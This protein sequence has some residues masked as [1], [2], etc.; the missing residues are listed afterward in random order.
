MNV[1][2]RRELH[3]SVSASLK[4]LEPSVMIINYKDR[5]LLTIFTLPLINDLVAR[6][7]GTLKDCSKTIL[8][9]EHRTIV[10]PAGMSLML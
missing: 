2:A 1:S 6:E 3:T 7:V 5:E 9:V 8:G 10:L 4:V